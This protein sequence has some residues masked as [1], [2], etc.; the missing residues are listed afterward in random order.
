MTLHWSKAGQTQ[1]GKPP[2]RTSTPRLHTNHARAEA[3]SFATTPGTTPTTSRSEGGQ[4]IFIRSCRPNML[5]TK[6]LTSDTNR[7]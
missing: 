1:K 3:V 4:L 6:D 2:P 7:S 5:A